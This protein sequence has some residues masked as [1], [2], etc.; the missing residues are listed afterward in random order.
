[1]SRVNPFIHSILQ[2]KVTSVSMALG[3][4]GEMH[5]LRQLA[6][7]SPNTLVPQGASDFL[8]FLSSCLL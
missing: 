3:P 2:T 5:L 6:D 4:L 1:M 8:S 7:P